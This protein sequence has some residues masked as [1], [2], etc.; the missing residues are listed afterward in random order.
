MV[1]DKF[2]IFE[3]N[4]KK[5]D[6]FLDYNDNIELSKHGNSFDKLLEE[7][8]GVIFV[9]HEFGFHNGKNIV[10]LDIR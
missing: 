4:N 1:P 7:N 3:H 5:Y 2:R 10:L 9:R 8:Q 6:G